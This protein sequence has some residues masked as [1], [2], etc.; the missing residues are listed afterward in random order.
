[1]YKVEV[2]DRKSARL[3]ETEY[4]K[5]GKTDWMM[6]ILGFSM[7]ASFLFSLVMLMFGFTDDSPIVYHLLGIIE[8]AI[9]AMMYYYWGSSKDSRK[10]TEMLS[11]VVK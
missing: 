2:D 6:M 4:V 11:K 3:R 10:K 9:L 7:L 5:A 8:G 1:M